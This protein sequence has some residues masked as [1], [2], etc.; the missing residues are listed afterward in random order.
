MWLY[1]TALFQPGQILT[2]AGGGK[3]HW[4][5][6]FSI[7]YILPIYCWSLTENP[8]QILYLMHESEPSWIDQWSE[9]DSAWYAMGIIKSSNADVSAQE[10]N[11]ENFNQS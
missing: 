11:P 7:M 9:F 8:I 6:P 4:H 10:H 3:P 5:L 2:L 1:F